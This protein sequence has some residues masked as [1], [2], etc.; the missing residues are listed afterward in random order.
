MKIIVGLVLALSFKAQ[1]QDLESI[2]DE[3]SQ[4]PAAKVVK[5][6]K[7]VSQG[8]PVTVAV[9]KQ[10][11][12]LNSEQQIFLRFVEAAEWDKATLQFLQAFEGTAFQ[13][14]SSGRALFGYV[15]FQAGLP[16]TGTETLFL[17]ENP[18]Q[19]AFE[20]AELWKKALPVNHFAWDMA[21]VGWS[22]AW[23]NFF[24]PEIETKLKLQKLG[25]VSDIE[26]LKKLSARA[27]PN[28]IEKAQIEW[29][30]ALAYSMKDQPDVAAKTLA[31]LMKATKKPISEDLL[32]ITAARLLFQN[33]YFDA[34]SKY[35]DRVSKKS[36]YWTEAQEEKAW[37]FI[38]KG[39]PQNAIA[40]S[41]SLTVPAMASQVS[42]EAYFVQALG[43]LKICD[44]AGVQESLTTFPKRF[45]ARTKKLVELSKGGQSAD[46]DKAIAQL[47]KG[48]IQ[49]Q[50]IG[51]AAASLP[52]LTARDQKLFQ[53]VQTQKHYENEA[54]VAEVLYSKSLALTG[55][56]GF[57]ENL[58]KNTLLKA[59][60]AEAAAANRVKELAATE[61]E[62]TKEI[63]RKMHIV[64]AELIQQ[65]SIADRVARDTATDKIAVKNGTTGSKDKH[66]MTF[67]AENEVWFDE[68]GSYKVDV[69]K[70][71][72]SKRTL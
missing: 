21:R 19:I 28:T 4:K 10:V 69:K 47:K 16:I 40:V 57:F 49:I 37:A 39:E 64:E 53:F 42:P 54:R 52:R 25:K 9:K 6:E 11:Q 48:K 32:Q 66:A 22:P 65:V 60:A 18:N 71:C 44:Y 12:T 43:Q 36:D 61:V 63:L 7:A 68:I 17:A 35:Y 1:A 30:L 58:K 26:T 59:Q 45:Q 62:E 27:T 5:K 20:I 2:L 3:G 13:K 38:R 15:Q 14:S 50:D 29:Q 41:R 23:E 70:A 34:A 33:G 67:P 24:G 8:H 56:Q 55:L 46:A 31:G 51:A 72:H